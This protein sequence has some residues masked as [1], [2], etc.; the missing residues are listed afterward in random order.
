MNTIRFE[1]MINTLQLEQFTYVVREPTFPALQ[2]HHNR[3]FEL[4]VC[5]EGEV[6]S[7]IQNR[8]ILLQA[9]DGIFIKP[10]VRHQFRNES[11]KSY[12]FY[13]LHF[14]IDDNELREMLSTTPFRHIRHEQEQGKR[15]ADCLANIAKL[16]PS[17]EEG[18]P[19]QGH[20]TVRLAL[21]NKL[22][23]QAYVLLI[24]AQIT[25]LPAHAPDFESASR[26]KDNTVYIIDTAHH[27]EEQL[28]QLLYTNVSITDIANRLNISGSQC[29]KI[30]RQV[31]GVSPRHYLSQLKLNEAK[32]LLVTTNT[33]VSEISKRLG[34]SS[35][36]HFSRQFRRWTGVSPANFRPKHSM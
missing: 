20:I 15:L 35:I 32:Q 6:V 5:K 26:I 4:F 9:G 30:F 36:N 17:A 1:K 29:T 11:G 34:F 3:L 28:I 2:K 18:D 22:T 14:D 25:S 33:P 8:S 19:G 16:L 27:I 7:T 21:A 10:G 13:Q 12:S 23:F 31:Y 24:I